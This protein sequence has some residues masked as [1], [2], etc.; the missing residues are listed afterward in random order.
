MT[1]VNWNKWQLPYDQ[2]LFMKGFIL[3]CGIMFS[4]FMIS[5]VLYGFVTIID[6]VGSIIALPFFAY[7]YQLYALIKEEE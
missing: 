6:I 3:A 1:A 2:S 5:T 7:L 4:W